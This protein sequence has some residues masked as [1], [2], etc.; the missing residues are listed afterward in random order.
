MSEEKDASALDPKSTPG[1]LK[2][3]KLPSV[4]RINNIPL[5]LGVGAVSLIMVLF[6]YVYG[7]VLFLKTGSDHSNPA[8]QAPCKSA[9]Q[10]LLKIMI[11]IYAINCI[12][13]CIT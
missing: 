8:S 2:E 7:Y 1:E 4:R 10:K 6:I 11:F 5:I 12:Y 13:I 9:P 3:R